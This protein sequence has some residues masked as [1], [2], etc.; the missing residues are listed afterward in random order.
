MA[1]E[2][3]TIA[4]I[5]KITE[6][7]QLCLD[8]VHANEKI[9]ELTALVDDKKKRL[10][11]LLPDTEEEF[12]VTDEADGKVIVAKWEDKLTKTLQKALVEQNHGITLTE[13]DYKQTP[14]H[15]VGIK[16]VKA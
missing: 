10:G 6:M 8:I 1:T 14:S 2:T 12:R 13:E 15:Y 9:K 4:K 3:F 16:K 5:Q 7:S 11:E